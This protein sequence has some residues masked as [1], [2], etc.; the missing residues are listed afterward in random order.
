VKL[1]VLAHALS[2]DLVTSLDVA[3][4]ANFAG[5]VLD[6]SAFPAMVDTSQTGRREIVRLIERGGLALTAIDVRLAHQGFS[7]RGDLQ[8]ELDRVSRAIDIARGLRGKLV[9]CDL[10]PLPAAPHEASVPRA[11]IAPSALGRLILPDP[12]KADPPPP[13]MPRDL[14]FEATLETALREL[15]ERADKTGCL[16]AF[17]SSLGSFASLA[18]ALRSVDCGYFG[19]DLDTLALLADAWSVDAVFDAIGGSIRHIRSRDGQRGAGG[20]VVPSEVGKGEVDWPLLFSLCRDADFDGP[21]TLDTID[22]PDRKGSAI[23][24]AAALAGFPS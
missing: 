6:P 9:L 14:A 20:R 23:R 24:G 12:P 5:V 11:P 3:R 13:S 15:A 17:R 1:S 16:I 10:G 2:T 4:R 8:R 21:F 19:V 7:P 18:R 22:L